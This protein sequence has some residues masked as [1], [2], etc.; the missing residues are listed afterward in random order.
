MFCILRLTG[1]PHRRTFAQSNW[2][3]SDS[4]SSN[5]QRHKQTYY[6]AV[7]MGAFL[8]LLL[9]ANREREREREQEICRCCSFLCTAI[10]EFAYV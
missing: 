10:T 8:S 4:V 5:S 1:S 2:T 6:C 3:T 9:A 7:C